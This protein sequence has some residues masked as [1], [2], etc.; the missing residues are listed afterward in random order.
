MNNAVTPGLYRHYKGNIYRVIG[1]ARHT[2]TLEDYV[3]YESIS[4]SE[5]KCWIRPLSM[6]IETIEIK[7]AK[8][9]RFMKVL[10]K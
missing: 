5:K 2:E 1:I 9:P 8:T 6:F 7:G 3:V 4:E 10:E